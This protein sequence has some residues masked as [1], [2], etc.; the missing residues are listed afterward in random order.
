MAHE[1]IGVIYSLVA[2]LQIHDEL[3]TTFVRHQGHISDYLKLQ[4]QKRQRH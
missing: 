4:I 3:L 1:A 2:W